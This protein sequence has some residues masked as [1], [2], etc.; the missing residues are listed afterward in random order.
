MCEHRKLLEREFE[1]QMHMFDREMDK[2]K[3]KHRQL[4]EQSVIFCYQFYTFCYNISIKI[5]A[6]SSNFV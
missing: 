6:H 2:L 1:N 3:S 4:L 5:L